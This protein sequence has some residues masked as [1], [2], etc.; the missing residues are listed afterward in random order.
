MIRKVIIDTNVLV[1]ALLASHDDSATVQVIKLVLKGRIIPVITKSIISEYNEVLRR[2][3]FDFP[4]ES[5]SML[6]DYFTGKAIEAAPIQT[7]IKLPDNKDLPFFEAVLS[8]EDHILITGNTKHFP[9]HERIITPR[10][11]LNTLD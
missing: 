2:K 9:V 6:I 10:M 4:E 5:I 8:A 1:S 7:D 3:K 11:F